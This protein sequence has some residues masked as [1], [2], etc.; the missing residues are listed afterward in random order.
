MKKYHFNI[1]INDFKT[2][3]GSKAVSDCKKILM[4]RSY[5]DI[6]LS[7]IKNPL[8][9]GINVVK[10]LYGL[11]SRY[12]E[13]ESG[14]LIIVQYPLKG[15]N[16]HFRHFIRL[17]KQK[18]CSFIAIV[19][20]LD[21]LRYKKPATAIRAEID[22]LNA[23]DVVISHNEKMTSWLREKGLKTQVQNLMIFDYLYEEGSTEKRSDL[24]AAGSRE[25]AFAGSLGRGKFIFGLKGMTQNL[26]FRLYGP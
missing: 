15:I 22:S 16:R 17:M 23:Y 1:L 4:E 3:A 12:F 24:F 11:A 21:S 25:V 13:I 26:T 5:V 9:L 7:F 6:D 18:Q 2:N 19:H 20:D 10:L 14:S 8:L